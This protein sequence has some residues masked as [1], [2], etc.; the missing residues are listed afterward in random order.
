MYDS[1]AVLDGLSGIPV[2]FLII[3]A[4]LFAGFYGYYIES[5]RLGLKQR[6]YCVPVGA[7]M[8]NF[9]HDLV[10]VA[11]FRHWFH[12]V[13]HW[14]FKAFWWGLVV[15][16]AME[17]CIHAQTLRYGRRDLFPKLGR[18]HF[19]LAYLGM[20]AGFVIAFLF[21]LSLLPGD[22]LFLVK[23]SISVA[24][25]A[26]FGLAFVLRR[27]GSSSRLQ[28]VLLLVGA[29]TMF[30]AFLP[31]LSPFFESAVYRS[32]GVLA[33][34]CAAIYLWI[35]SRSLQRRRAVVK[36]EPAGSRARSTDVNEGPASPARS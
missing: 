3:G 35:V 32:L 15:F 24:L 2:A 11:M 17:L 13:D 5:I 18:A 1:Q 20:Q 14:V 16:M 22:E 12:E 25:N 6:T 36:A 21:L 27:E 28:A 7:N 30:F 4:V 29:V 23:I 8:F 19:V 33:V 9:A 31:L 34:S 26:A 10:F